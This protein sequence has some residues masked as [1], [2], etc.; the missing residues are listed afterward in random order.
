[1][2]YF[3]IYDER[4]HQQYNVRATD[5]DRITAYLKD[6][7]GMTEAQATAAAGWMQNAKRFEDFTV[8]QFTVSK[9]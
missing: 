5:A 9:V 1:M 8:G 4:K 2:G 6:R 7:C 3:E